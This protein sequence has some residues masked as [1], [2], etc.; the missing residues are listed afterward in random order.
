MSRTPRGAAP[1]AR[2]RAS[3][4]V[5]PRAHARQRGRLGRRRLGGARGRG[6]VRASR[7]A[8]PQGSAWPPGGGVPLPVAPPLPGALAGGRARRMG[9]TFGRETA[10]LER[11]RWGRLPDEVRCARMSRL[12]VAGCS[13]PGAP[14]PGRAPYPTFSRCT[15]PPF[16]LR[17]GAR[18]LPGPGG[19]GTS[20][21]PPRGSLWLL[22][23]V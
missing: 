3:R 12:C 1:R 21:A 5:A 22:I 11:P 6:C 4:A 8:P 2:A 17:S 20:R 14:G 23:P 16:G 19:R 10:K 18:C 15:G 13:A 9:P 7:A